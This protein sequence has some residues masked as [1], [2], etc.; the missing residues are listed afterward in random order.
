MVARTYKDQH[1]IQW[2]TKWVKGHTDNTKSYDTLTTLKC[3]NVCMDE[4]VGEHFID[5]P[6]NW[7]NTLYVPI[8]PH[9]KWALYLHGRKVMKQLKSKV[10]KQLH[11]LECKAYI[12]TKLEQSR[13][14]MQQI[15]WDGIEFAL[16]GIPLRACT[17][18]TKYMY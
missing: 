17:K 6:P 7:Q 3:L 18:V 5:T 11:G 1:K 13:S 15:E 14:Q 4:N 8:F 2:T 12:K 10:N 9:E 16:S